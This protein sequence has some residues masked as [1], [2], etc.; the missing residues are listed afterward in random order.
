MKASEKDIDELLSDV[1]MLT[2]QTKVAE[3]AK[4]LADEE[5]EKMLDLAKALVQRT[6]SRHMRRAY[7]DWANE[8]FGDGYRASSETKAKA[9]A[10]RNL[11]NHTK[12]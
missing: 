4:E 6:G 7:L 5:R 8:V 2:H 12:T 9:S 10:V 11:L 3:I 1:A